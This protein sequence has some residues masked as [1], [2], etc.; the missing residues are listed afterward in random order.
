[1]QDVGTFASEV[2]SL[3]GTR[4]WPKKEVR[5]IRDHISFKSNNLPRHVGVGGAPVSGLRRSWG[6]LD[7]LD[8]WYYSDVASGDVS[9]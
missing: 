2:L 9:S 7:D 3:R 8:H 1:M 5:A 6:E 4:S